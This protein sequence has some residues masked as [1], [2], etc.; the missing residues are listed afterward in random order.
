MAKQKVLQAAELRK[1]KEKELHALLRDA[2]LKKAKDA[3]LLQ[4]GKSKDTSLV[5]KSKKLVARIKTVI[6]EQKLL[7]ILTK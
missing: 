4:T 2:L 6:R 7:K 3:L 5:G 1:K